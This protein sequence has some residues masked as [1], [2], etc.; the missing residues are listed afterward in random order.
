[1]RESVGSVAPMVPPMKIWQPG[2]AFILPS[3]SL[4]F[5]AGPPISPISAACACRSKRFGAAGEGKGEERG[6]GSEGRE[7]G[8]KGS[9]RTGG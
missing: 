4:H 9:E 3:A 6:A 5:L 7:A 2:T 8:G 1:M